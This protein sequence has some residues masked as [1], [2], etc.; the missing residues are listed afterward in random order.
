MSDLG[1]SRSCER[2][3]QIQSAIAAGWMMAVRDLLTVYA[4]ECELAVVRP[5]LCEARVGE[6]Q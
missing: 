5:G 4:M 2:V 1:K 6:Y 3:G